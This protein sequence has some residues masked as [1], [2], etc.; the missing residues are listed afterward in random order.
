MKERPSKRPE[1]IMVGWMWNG[2]ADRESQS[3][4]DKH[5]KIQETKKVQ[6]HLSLNEK[7]MWQVFTWSS[8]FS[9]R[10]K[11]DYRKQTLFQKQY[12]FIYLEQTWS[13]K[14]NKICLN[15]TNSVCIYGSHINVQMILKK[16]IEFILLAYTR[17]R[18]AETDWKLSPPIISLSKVKYVKLCQTFRNVLKLFLRNKAQSRILELATMKVSTC[19]LSLCNDFKYFLKFW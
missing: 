1:W 13:C 4:T 16:K 12:G 9:C 3:Q 15:K 7:Q 2:W 10:S 8:I 17:V 11:L 18:I 14:H 5:N 19:L 6:L